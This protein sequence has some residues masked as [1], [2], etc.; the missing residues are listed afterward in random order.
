MEHADHAR[1]HRSQSLI[2]SLTTN[3]AT[4]GFVVATLGLA[5]VSWVFVV[6][7]MNG[8]DMGVAT[9]LGSLASFVAIWV[10]MMAAMMLPGAAPTVLRSA[11]AG[12]AMRAVPLFVGSYLAIWTVVGIALYALYRPHGTF[13]AG[14]VVLA[15][16]VYELTPF[17]RH[18]RRRCQEIAHSGFDYGL[19]CVGST[20]GLML[21]L[22]ALGIM[23]ILWMTIVAV[24]VLAQKLLHAR[25]ALDVPLAFAIG[26]LGLLITVAP[27]WVPG[28]MPPM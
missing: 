3:V 22:V 7:R 12:G 14:M 25:A 20:I 5:V 24:I 6:Q 16:G 9:Q 2:A 4:N 15:A 28:L 26:G 8:M 10:A 19:S 13:S 17:K 1:G 11:H 18:F 27:T 23:S 21:M